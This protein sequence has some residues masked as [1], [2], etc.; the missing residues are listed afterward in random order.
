MASDEKE[1]KKT[2]QL[3]VSEF[4]RVVKWTF[5]IYLKMAP[6]KTVA[7]LLTR[8]VMDMRSI[9][10]ALIF[11][12]VIDQLV[13][14]AEGESSDLKELYPYL[15]VLFL[16]SVFADGI[17]QQIYSFSRRGLRHLSR[18]EME[19]YLFQKINKLGVQTLEDPDVANNIQRSQE[20]IYSTHELIENSVY[21][22]ANFIRV[23]TAAIS[24]AAFFPFY[25][26]V[27]IILTLL[28]YIPDK[29]FNRQ[30]FK[31]QVDNSEGKRKAR[32]TAAMLESPKNLHE[33]NIV[34]G[35]GFL[36]R[37]YTDFFDWYNGGILKIFRNIALVGI[38]INFIDSLVVI[39]G[40]GVIFNNLILDLITV[41]TLMFQMR[42]L[43]IFTNSAREA[44][45]ELTFL[46]DFSI[47]M[48]DVVT[49]FNMEPK[50]KDGSYQL[51]RLQTPPE[52]ELR[53]VTFRYPKA[54]NYVFENLDLKINSGEKIA[55]VG[56]NGAGKTTLVKLL[57]RIYTPEKG[58]ILINGIDLRDMKIDDWYKNLG[59]LFQDYNF[60]EH[61]SV[62]EN[63][64]LGK[65]VKELDPKRIVE[66]A[67]N[68][69]ADDFIN[70]LGNKY[71]TIMSERYEGGT[72]P[73]SGQQQ[74]IAIARFFYRNAPLAIFDEPTSAIDAVSEYKI[75]NKIYSFFENKTVVIISHRFST[76][77]NA[78]RIIVMEKGRVAEEGNHHDLLTLGGVYAN[79]YKLQAEG[80][81]D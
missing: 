3:S 67:E 35:Y 76:V 37:K 54:E 39:I 32:N 46:N 73:S 59:I 48:K 15:G 43:D 36:S 75:F 51:P 64:Y 62:E 8:I 66:A 41:G 9:T 1:K 80:Y 65:S 7:L 78:D 30:D 40:Y 61:L 42:A 10:Y 58:S 81:K 6:G 55:I 63:I 16:Y 34:G 13:A 24:V 79:A 49:L 27:V 77:R 33:I 71:K 21:V 74:K 60:Y 18:N 45:T 2:E 70:G 31:W 47:K 56:H 14:L 50:V 11:A 12:K 57:A 72:R 26:P 20:W 5:S 38:L 52:I 23:S 25:I 53:N 68:A 19:K 44:L 28:K 4:L 29:H 22:I 69:D 17:I